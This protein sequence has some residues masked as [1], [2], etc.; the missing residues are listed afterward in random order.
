[1]RSVYKERQV[2]TDTDVIKKTIPGKPHCDNDSED[3]LIISD[4]QSILKMVR[5][6]MW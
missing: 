3:C 5:G 1:M 6:I 4:E 2:K